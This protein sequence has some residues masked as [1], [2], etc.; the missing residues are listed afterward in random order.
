MNISPPPVP[1]Q[2]DALV[3]GMGNTA[4]TVTGCDPTLPC[5]A[6][7]VDDPTGGGGNI[8]GSGQ[9]MRVGMTTF[10]GSLAVGM[11]TNT[12]SGV[13]NRFVW[14]Q[15]GSAGSQGHAFRAVGGSGSGGPEILVLAGSIGQARQPI[16]AAVQ[17]KP[18]F[19]ADGEP[20]VLGIRLMTLIFSGA[21]GLDGGWLSEPVCLAADQLP[22]FWQLHK[23]DDHRWELLLRQR[24]VAVV[25]YGHAT[26]D[27]H[28]F[29]F[30]MRLELQD[31]TMRAWPRTVTIAPAP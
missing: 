3:D 9:L 18:E 12:A 17:L 31:K 23:R 27:E 2:G 16:P 6:W 21:V 1:S 14:V 11:F 8:T 5:A 4:V 20:D 13:P 24:D 25:A 22:A 10:N 7:I 30:P 15:Q 26:T 29:S 19:P 28:D